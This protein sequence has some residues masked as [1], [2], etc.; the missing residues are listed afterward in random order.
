MQAY[1]WAG[2]LAFA[3]K[4]VLTGFVV[5][6]VVR[7]FHAQHRRARFVESQRATGLGFSIKYLLKD[8]WDHICGRQATTDRFLAFSRKITGAWWKDR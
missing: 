5:A 2:P 4:T 3:I 1:L 6:A 8:N 7:P